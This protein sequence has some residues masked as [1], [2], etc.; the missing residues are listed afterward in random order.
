MG[1]SPEPNFRFFFYNWSNA[2]EVLHLRMGAD[3]SRISVWDRTDF[4][5][6]S[7]QTVSVTMHKSR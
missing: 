2:D 5:D 6:G 7:K 3:R 4:H 1:D